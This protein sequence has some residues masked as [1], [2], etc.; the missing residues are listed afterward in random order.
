MS[1]ESLARAQFARELRSTGP[2]PRRRA[3]VATW[4]QPQT[5]AATEGGVVT[6][7]SGARGPAKAFRPAP[8]E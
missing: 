8:R 2:F 4:G 5:I 3:G 7:A 6:L 1:I